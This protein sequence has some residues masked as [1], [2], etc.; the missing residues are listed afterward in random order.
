MG[1]DAQLN[2]SCARHV[3]SGFANVVLVNHVFQSCLHNGPASLG[4]FLFPFRP[5][6]VA[7]PISIK[8]PVPFSTVLS[9]RSVTTQS[10]GLWKANSF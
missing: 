8:T 3:L 10:S 1:T 2:A 4:T 7:M 9:I 6:L 5:G